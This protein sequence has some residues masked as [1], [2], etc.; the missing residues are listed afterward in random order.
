M[1]S[2]INLRSINDLKEINTFFCVV[3]NK[4]V[5]DGLFGC[6]VEPKNIG[7]QKIFKTFPPVLSHFMYVSFFIF[8]RLFPKLPITSD[9]Y[10]YLTGGR[11][12][13]MSKT[14]VMG[15]LY[16]CGFQYVDEK[17]I[18]N[19]IYFVF[20]KIRK[21][22]ANHN[23]KYGAIFK[24]RRHGKDGKIIYVYKLRTMD[25]Y[26]EYLQHYVYEKNNLAEGG[27]MKDDFRVSTLGRFFR[28]YWID[29]LPMII[30]LLKG[31]LKFVG[32]RPL[33]SHYLSLYSEELREKRIHHKP[34]LIP[35]FYVDL[36]KSLDDIMK[37][38]M[39]YLEAYEK[40]PLL[41]D[42]KYFFLAFYTIVFKKARSK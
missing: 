9:I 28:K 32:V 38:E 11:T 24:M 8:H 31:D 41:T 3:N 15:R 1:N 23:A 39:K 22:I 34:G 36:P 20:R 12:P 40:H 27:K 30:N 2:I 35:P 19:K 14:E 5:T 42:M 18:N 13:V 29:E 7:K 21:P 10:F 16:A 4:L 17:R 37:S 33:S 6:C 26:S 25:A